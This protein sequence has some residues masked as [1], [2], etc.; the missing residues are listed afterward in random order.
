MGHLSLEA[1][2]RA[3]DLKSRD[4]HDAGQDHTCAHHQVDFTVLKQDKDIPLHA[5]QRQQLAQHMYLGVRATPA[6]QDGA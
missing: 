1:L 5:D 6:G 2:L 4:Q 3:K